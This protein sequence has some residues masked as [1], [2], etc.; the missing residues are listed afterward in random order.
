MTNVENRFYSSQLLFGQNDVELTFSNR[1]WSMKFS[2]PVPWLCKYQLESSMISLRFG[3]ISHIHTSQ[4]HQA[5]LALKKYFKIRTSY[6]VFVEATKLMRHC[7]KASCS[8]L[9]EISRWKSIWVS[10]ESSPQH[11]PVKSVLVC[12]MAVGGAF[13]GKTCKRSYR[14]FFVAWGCKMFFMVCEYVWW[15]PFL[16]NPGRKWGDRVCKHSLSI[17]RHD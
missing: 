14:D 3:T 4:H 1:S 16:E 7:L 8:R 10:N 11:G 17:G 15:W 9:G 2:Y 6:Y 13:F 12:Q 5:S